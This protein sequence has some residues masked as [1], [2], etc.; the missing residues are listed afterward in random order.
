MAVGFD[1]SKRPWSE[2]AWSLFP[3]SE[4]ECGHHDLARRPRSLCGAPGRWWC[5]RSAGIEC[6]HVQSR[7]GYVDGPVDAEPPRGSRMAE[8]TARNRLSPKLIEVKWHTSMHTFRE[9]TDIRSV[10]RT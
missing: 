4:F 9:K 6:H 3:L 1:R 8:P 10:P 7:T 2:T 5:R